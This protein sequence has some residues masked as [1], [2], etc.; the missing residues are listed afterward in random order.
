[1]IIAR[2]RSNDPAVTLDCW[3]SVSFP[4]GSGAEQIQTDTR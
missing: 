2:M 4:A 3:A 1:M